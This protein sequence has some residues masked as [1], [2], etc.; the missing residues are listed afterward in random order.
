[1]LGGAIGGTGRGG[2]GGAGFVL[3]GATGGT[4]RGGMGGAGFVTGGATGGTGRGGMGGA[5]LVLGGATGGVGLGC[6]G[7]AGLGR[8]G[9]IGGTGTFSIRR[10]I[11]ILSIDFCSFFLVVFEAALTAV[12]SILCRRAARVP[13]CGAAKCAKAIKNK[14]SE[15]GRTPVSLFYPVFQ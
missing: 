1:M 11:I 5:G 8:G 6:D 7:G 9:A 3:G 12:T 14:K 4:G 2:A 15:T 13:P 10:N